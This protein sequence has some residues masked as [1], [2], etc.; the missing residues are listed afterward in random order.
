MKRFSKKQKQR[1]KSTLIYALDILANDFSA[2]E[3][4]TQEIKDKEVE[5]L[6]DIELTEQWIWKVLKDIDL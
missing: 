2:N 6:R 4:D 1:I 3:D 5:M